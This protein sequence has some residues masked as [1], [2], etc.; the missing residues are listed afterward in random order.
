MNYSTDLVIRA[1]EIYHDLEGP[2]YEKRHPEIF[3]RE[4]PH[5]RRIS[6][7]WIAGDTRKIRVLD[8]G[9]GTGFVAQQVGKYLKAGDT[10]IC[11][12]V[13]AKMLEICKRNLSGLDYRCD[14]Q[15]LKVDGHGIDIPE[16]SCD[17]ITLNS[18]LHHIPDYG[19]FLEALGRLLRDDG[20]ILIAHEPNKAFYSHRL[21]W[22]NYKIVSMLFPRR[23]LKEALRWLGLLKMSRKVWKSSARV[24]QTRLVSAVNARLMDDGLIAAPLTMAQVSEIV[25]LHSPLA[26]GRLRRDSGIEI[27]KVLIDNLRGYNLE[28]LETD[29]HLGDLSYTNRLARLYASILKAR[30]PERGSLVSVSLKRASIHSH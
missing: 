2:D 30:Y 11:A 25:D 14:I 26:G 5:W 8:V 29:A 15:Y 21:L 3:D 4:R 17:Y 16:D 27:H 12:D 13:S 9:C 18:V 19:I 23:L 20:R 28:H 6:H 24:S 22:M 10:F 1:N 7:R